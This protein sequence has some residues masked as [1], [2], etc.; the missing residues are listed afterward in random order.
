MPHRSGKIPN[1]TILRLALYSRPLEDLLLEETPV[2]S[3]D[4]LASLCGVNPAQVRKDLAYFG[5]FGI[6]GVGYDVRHLLMAIKKILATDRTWNLCLVGVGNLGSSLLDN[7]NFRDRGYVF[8]AAFDLD[9]NK[10]GQKHAC[11]LIIEPIS[12]LQEVCVSRKIEIGV[13]ATPPH[14]A[15]KV[16]DLLSDAG[17]KAVLNF[18]PTQVRSAQ[19]CTVEN[20]DLS[21]KLENLVY[22]LVRTCRDP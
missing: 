13:I 8:V 9:P 12:K 21:V 6:R 10:V 22:H 11:G 4:K 2:V 18:A 5:E 16:M 3:S 17:V 14:E 19:C 20:V 1:P 15:Q 7:H